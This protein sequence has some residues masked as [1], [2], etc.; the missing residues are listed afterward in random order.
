MTLIFPVE[1]E[2]WR[3]ENWH[4]E[5][6]RKD[7]LVVEAGALPQGREV[8]GGCAVGTCLQ[9]DHA[10]LQISEPWRWTAT[11]FRLR[12]VPTRTRVD[13]KMSWIDSRRGREGRMTFGDGGAHPH[14]AIAEL[15]L[16]RLLQGHRHPR[17]RIIPYLAFTLSF[18]TV[19]FIYIRQFK[20][21]L[22]VDRGGGAHGRGLWAANPPRASGAP[23]RPA[24][25]TVGVRTFLEQGNEF[26]LASTNLA[27][28]IL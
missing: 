13:L 28:E 3:T 12:H 19:L 26:I 1:D 14:H 15:H 24:T 16:V 25:M 20:T 22:K 7:G 18:N 11:G 6:I 2:R 9:E 23:G 21:L 17:R 5:V 10:T 27:T 8:F 4:L